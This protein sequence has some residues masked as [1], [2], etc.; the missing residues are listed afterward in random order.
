MTHEEM[1]KIL[2]TIEYKDWTFIIV[3]RDHRLYDYGIR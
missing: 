2:E 1:D 3:K